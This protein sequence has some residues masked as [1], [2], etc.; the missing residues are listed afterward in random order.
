MKERIISREDVLK[1]AKLSRLKLS[2][3]EIS[4][5]TEQ[6]EKILEYMEKLK[7]V[8]T[9]GISPT[10]YPLPLENV[11]REDREIPPLPRDK[12]LQNAPRRKENYFK[13]PRII[14]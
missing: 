13:V 6:L 11:W 10:F 8:D 12:V 1:V 3:E 7:E 4:L 5:Y 9:R 2:E 14:E